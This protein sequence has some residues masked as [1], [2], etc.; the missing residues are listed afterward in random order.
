[1]PEIGTKKIIEKE[2]YKF[3]NQ[4]GPRCAYKG[5]LEMQN[6]RQKTPAWAKRKIGH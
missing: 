2:K 1:M 5:K 3:L 4:I 6:I